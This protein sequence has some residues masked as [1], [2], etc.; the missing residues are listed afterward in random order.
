MNLLYICHCELVCSDLMY[1]FLGKNEAKVDNKGRIFVPA[2]YRRMLESAGETSLCMRVDPITKCAKLYPASE[3]EKVIAELS[4]KLNPYNRDDQRML[5]YF[6]S[7]IEPIEL[8]ASG[9]VLIQ[10][11]HLDAIEVEGEALFVGMNNYFEI[12][13]NGNLEDDMMSDEDFAAALQERLGGT[14]AF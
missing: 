9:R 6:M 4:A 8:D 1:K 10:K 12:W 11:K 3:M 14:I 5:R 2:A 7:G 13:K